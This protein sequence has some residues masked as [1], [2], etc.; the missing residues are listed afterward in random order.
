M[1]VLAAVGGL[2]AVDHADHHA[3][4]RAQDNQGGQEVTPPA[5]Q[6]GMDLRWVDVNGVRLPVSDT[7]GP[8]R[9]HDGLA[10]GF[11]HDELGAVIAAAAL[12]YRTSAL[13]GPAVYR[14]TITG[15]GVGDPDAQLSEVDASYTSRVS[16][17]GVSY[18]QPLPAPNAHVVGY[19]IL[20]GDPTGD[21]VV[22]GLCV[23]TLRDG[24]EVTYLGHDTLHWS[25][26]DWRIELPLADPT[27]TTNT[28][29]CTPLPGG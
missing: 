24:S 2:W 21:Q 23:R 7:H 5:S 26:Q 15:Q 16:A 28:N 17:A 12:D 9:Q 27:P 13:P 8:T 25:G 1:L 10:F 22:V 20:A 18:G 3:T 14:A 6:E 19:R 29:G 4:T 11:S